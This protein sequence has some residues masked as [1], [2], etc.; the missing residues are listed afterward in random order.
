MTQS[1]DNASVDTL[2]RLTDI[3]MSRCA[4]YINTAV[5]PHSYKE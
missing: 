5:L 3:I 4:S 2:Y 1:H